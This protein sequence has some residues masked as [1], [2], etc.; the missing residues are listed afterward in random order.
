MNYQPHSANSNIID[1]KLKGMAFLF[2]FYITRIS[3]ALHE[4]GIFKTRIPLGLYF[5]FYQFVSE[6]TV[7]LFSHQF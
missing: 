6:A 5:S 4:K 2:I 1:K 7:L 3:G